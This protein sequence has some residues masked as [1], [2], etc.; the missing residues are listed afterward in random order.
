IERVLL[1]L[2]DTESILSLVRYYARTGRSGDGLYM[3]IRKIAVDERPS[4]QLSGAVTLFPVPVDDLRRRLFS[5]A[6]T[7]TSEAGVARQCL[8]LID[9]MRDDYGYPESEARHPDIRSGQP[10]PLL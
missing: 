9:G 1:M 4:A 8:A 3:S 6:L 2:S 5:L 10:W 7:Q